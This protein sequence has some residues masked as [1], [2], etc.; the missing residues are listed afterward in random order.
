MGIMVSETL[1]VNKVSEG[2]KEQTVGAKK[3][4]R[5]WLS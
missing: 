4:T 1:N 3:M 5:M 2:F